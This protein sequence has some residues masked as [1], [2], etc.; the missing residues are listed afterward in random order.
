MKHRMTAERAV[1]VV[2]VSFALLAAPALIAI[3]YW[4]EPWVVAVSSAS[5][6]AIALAVGMLGQQRWA[7]HVALV[8]CEI[9]LFVCIGCIGYVGLDSNGVGYLDTFL[10]NN[11][12]GNGL[13]LLP[14]FALIL[15]IT[16]WQRRVLR[17]SDVK[18]MFDPVAISSSS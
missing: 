2:A 1:Q 8:W 13:H 5:A 6:I 11:V 18:A 17:R 16:I 7:R 12:S 4:R 14:Y 10:R 3:L 9:M 15:L